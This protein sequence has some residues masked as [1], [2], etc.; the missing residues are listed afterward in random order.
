[1]YSAMYNIHIVYSVHQ[2]VDKYEYRQ[3]S[4]G[5]RLPARI[6]RSVQSP[7]LKCLY[8]CNMGGHF[9]SDQI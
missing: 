8:A 7:T 2:R 4:I 3:T 5:I 9:I 1:M 6:R